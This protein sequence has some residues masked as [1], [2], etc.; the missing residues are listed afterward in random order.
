MDL[1]VY[2]K[3]HG[4]L[5][6]QHLRSGAYQCF[7]GIEFCHGRRILHR[8]LKPQ[9]VL[10]DVKE[11]RLVLADFGLSRLFSM[12]LKNYT[13]EVVTLWYRAPEILL[14]HGQIRYGPSMDIWSLGCII[15]EMATKNALF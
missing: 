13:H 6:D 15:P 9:N 8:D 5:K 3:K 1:R 14:G 10:I 4:P 7:R 2:M 12:P 11:M